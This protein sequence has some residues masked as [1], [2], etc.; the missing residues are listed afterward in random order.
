MMIGL[1]LHNHR[2]KQRY[3]HLDYKERK[4]N[5]PLFL[6]KMNSG[7]MWDILETKYTSIK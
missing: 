7:S 2:R 5:R 4:D 1:H 3:F 6:Y